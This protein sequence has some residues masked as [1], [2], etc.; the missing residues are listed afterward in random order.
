MTWEEAIDGTRALAL[1]EAWHAGRDLER[2]EWA[3]VVDVVEPL[4]RRRLGQ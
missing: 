2:E 1:I 4:L 3:V